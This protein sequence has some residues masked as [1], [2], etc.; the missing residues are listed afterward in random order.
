MK[1]QDEQ[2]V[3]PKYVIYRIAIGLSTYVP[4]GLILVAALVNNW[5]VVALAVLVFSSGVMIGGWVV[6][7][8]EWC[9][10]CSS[11]RKWVG[12]TCLGCGREYGPCRATWID[13]M[14]PLRCEQRDGHKGKHD[15]D[16]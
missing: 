4:A 9:A 14:N 10:H 2:M 12:N 7:Q 6:Q 1:Q 11:I 5:W 16:K 8:P 13:P 15:F 3:I